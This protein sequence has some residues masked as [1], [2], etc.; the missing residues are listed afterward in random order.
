MLDD[1]SQQATSPKKTVQEV[2]NE[3][4]NVADKPIQDSLFP[5]APCTHE[6]PEKLS[7]ILKNIASKKNIC[8][9]LCKENKPRT[10][11]REK[12]QIEERT[13]QEGDRDVVVIED[14]ASEGTIQIARD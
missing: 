13:T 8:K 12:M 2:E 4:K 9:Q 5:E 1:P 10:R 7:N 6:N 14:V 11:L 3:E